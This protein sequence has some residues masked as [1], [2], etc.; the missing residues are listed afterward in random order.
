M[1]NP[2]L[3]NGHTKIANEL[4]DALSKAMPGF[5]AGQVLLAIIR[6]TYGWHKKNDTIS[7]K[8]IQ[9]MTGLSRRSVIYAIQNLE[10][11]NMIVIDRV[12][13]RI[14]DIGLQKDHE[15][16]KPEARGD[17]Y[18]RAL[19]QKW[20]NYLS[21]RGATNCHNSGIEGCN[22]LS[23]GVQRI[24]NDVQI[25]A[26]PTEK[27][28]HEKVKSLHPQ[29]KETITKETIQKK[30]HFDLPDWLDKKTWSDFL[31]M[32]KKIKAPPT[33]RAKELLIKR[34]DELRQAGDDPSEVLNQ[35]IMN[36]WRE[37]SPSKEKEMAELETIGG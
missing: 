20:C 26:P 1:A 7:I 13:G 5:G 10:A 25:V 34:L 24:V 19:D 12:S 18:A 32:R 31:E 30:E 33:E 22:D 28:R 9:E 27:I 21:K 37:F 36:N 6:K 29:N 2:Q 23:K 35:S 3:E 11:K 4:M 8:Q 14:N 15:Q 17:S 16:W